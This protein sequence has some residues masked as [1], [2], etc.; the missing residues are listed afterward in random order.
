MFRITG[1]GTAAILALTIAGAACW[2]AFVPEATVMAAK[3]G[4]PGGGGGGD[5]APAGEI[6]WQWAEVNCWSMLADGSQ[7]LAEP[8]GMPSNELHGPNGG[9]RWFLQRRIVEGEFYPDGDPRMELFAVPRVGSAEVQLTDNPDLEYVILGWEFRAQWT[10]D[11]LKVAWVG[12]HW[13]DLDPLIDGPDWVLDA[14]IYSAEIEFDVNGNPIGLVSQP[15][16]TEP[17]VPVAVY[18]DDGIMDGFRPEI[19]SFSW[20]PDARAIVYATFMPGSEGIWIADFTPE[21]TPEDT[22]F[23][24]ITTSGFAPAWSPDGTLIA[25]TADGFSLATVGPDGLNPTIIVPGGSTKKSVKTSQEAR[26]SPDSQYIAYWRT[27]S[28]YS[29]IKC[30]TRAVYRTT[31]DGSNVKKLMDDA[32]A[33]AW[34]D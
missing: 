1:K 14:G 26:W 27:S 33:N 8:C 9:Q 29:C 25:Y 23:S 17:L 2:S 34:R 31:R 24:R 30:R 10:L 11:D 16:P 12:Q 22:V 7:V 19:H 3:G 13:V 15:D 32:F 21:F 4:K 28:S 20:A 6:F 18:N 5:T